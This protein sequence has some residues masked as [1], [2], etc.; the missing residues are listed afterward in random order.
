LPIVA[1]RDE[2]HE[3]HALTQ[4]AGMS[5]APSTRDTGQWSAVSAGPPHHTHGV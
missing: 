1:P 5:G 3:R 4:A 2:L